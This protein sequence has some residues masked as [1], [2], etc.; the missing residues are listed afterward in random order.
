ME[1]KVKVT[2]D[3]GDQKVVIEIADTP[4]G[5]SSVKI[6]FKPEIENTKNRVIGTAESMAAKYFNWLV[7]E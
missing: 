4:D 6:E 5:R 2:F 3:D 1:K 7:G